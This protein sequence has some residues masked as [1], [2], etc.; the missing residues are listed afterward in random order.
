[1]LNKL[2]DFLSASPAFREAFG[3]ENKGVHALYEMAEG[4]RP[5]YAAALSRKTGRQILYI[6]PSDAAAMRAADDCA[7]WLGGG[8]AMLP[9]QE[10]QFTRGVAS[11]ENSFQ[12][13]SV[14]QKARLGEIRVLC[15]PAD[16][17]MNR[18]MPP[19]KY[20]E[21]A[22][23]LSEGGRMEPAQLIEQ[24]VKMGYERVDMVEG[25]GQCALRGAIVDAFSPAE[26]GAT[27]I[28]FWDDE[29]DSIRA[30][31]PISQRSLDRMEE[32]IFYPAVEWLLP[33]EYAPII[34]ELIRAQSA[35]LPNSPLLSNLPPLPETEEEKEEAEKEEKQEKKLPAFR[36]YDTGI[37][38][39]LQD[40]DQL[41]SGLQHPNL[42]LWAGAVQAE[43]AWLWEYLDDP[44]IL[45]EEPE[46]TRARCQDRFGGFAED[47]KLTLERQEA[48][49][50][51]AALLR[52]WEDAAEAL[53]NRPVKL[54]QDLLRGMG[55][56]KP[57]QITRFAGM[58]APKYV[59]RFKEL[60]GEIATWKREG[61]L[62]LLMAG[63]EARSRRLQTAL[64]ELETPTPTW[65]ENQNAAAAM[66]AIWPRT[67]SHGFVLT[68]CKLAVIADSDIFG[69]GYRKTRT[70]K[71]AGEKIE[72]FTDLKEG[73]YVVHEA[74]G[75]GIFRGTVRLQSEGTYRDYLLIQYQGNDK[76]YVPTDQFDRVQKFIGGQ[77]NPPPLN[78]L[79][80]NEWDRQKKK[81]KAG[82]KKLAFDLVALYAARQ[83]NPGHACCEDT[84]WQRQFED[85]FPY[86]LTPDQDKAV[87]DIKRDME[88]NSNMDRLV[89]GDVGYGKTE[90]ALR[91][92]MKAV[93][94]GKQVALL[95]PTTILAQQHYYTMLKRFR[96][97]PVEIDVLSRFRSPKLQ[98]ETMQKVAE[99]KVDILVGT[100]RLLSKD[101]HF[102]DLGLLIVD[103]E[104]RF[105]VAHKEAIKNYK[106]TVD[107]LTL[108]A[109]PIPRTLHMSMV[110][111]RDMSL[112]QTPPEERYPV[113]TYVL[114]YNDAVI[115]DAIMRELSR[116]GQ[117]YFLYNQV[118]SIDQFAARLR[119][120]VPEARIAVGHGQMKENL[121]EDVMLDFYEG[122]FDVLL[123]STIIENG[124]DVPK[125]NTIIIYDA[126]RF[127]L[128]QLYQLR[129]RVGRSTRV[130]YA[131]FTVRPDKMLSE[132]AQKRLSAIREFTAFGSG[133]R[134]AMR[135]L[136]IRGA[137]NIFGPEQSGNVAAV[138]Y[139]MYCRLIEEAVREARGAQ[140]EEIPFTVETR[141][142][143]K[144]D[145]YL[146]VE[147]VK[148]ES[149]RM[150]VF[151]RI[152]LIKKREDREDVIEELIDRFG[153]VPES[154]MN[155]IEIA[156]LRGICG[157][158]GITRVNH[159]A[160]AMV[161][162][163]SPGA[164]PDPMKLYSALEKTDKRLLLSA[165]REPA[166]LLRD[167]KQTVDS[168]LRLS[169]PI[170]EKVEG[171]L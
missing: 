7:A 138:G 4:Q 158:L 141:V 28:E 37:D 40:A 144:V 10:L 55:D 135:D 152:A 108:S 91:A 168:L 107:V 125:A 109:T 50:E 124:L 93:M 89:C 159:V 157:R 161:F 59:S 97:F 169:V 128:S 87:T 171:L 62:V 14:L 149:Q 101:V 13:L 49:P 103:E 134:I 64:S 94:D 102:K 24:L 140:G 11:R 67:L 119:A 22:V 56:M 43:S 110:G 114:D 133:F 106:K 148:G 145:A 26:N 95:A 80:G 39:L 136:E 1:M 73:D 104:Q 146:P 42:S 30:F 118:R 76:L 99:G 12:R 165:S 19:E 29:V 35:R 156:H 84:P 105:G 51:Q 74:H 21:H 33:K 83:A 123:S 117:V 47:F 81:V 18:M 6:A 126:D 69:A 166:I 57:D 122:K 52:T 75:V 45:I 78:S 155:L 44:I 17:I 32:A 153:D 86:E 79:S 66:A 36:V 139:D 170:L 163:L 3:A 27:R 2:L 41:E 71:T 98:K 53:Q 63:G 154:V 9:A 68:E 116:Q 96:D 150:E 127:G 72:A 131:Y 60:A 77:D 54:M 142:E 46:R 92:A 143:I 38:R 8:A 151:K 147:Y 132:T 16:A 115:R 130:A 129:G 23:R 164:S 31:D 167:P 25:K 58:N 5:F 70:R 111:V 48:V 162:K 137:G 120:L 88:S 20:E 82:L 15:V 34:R 160:G 100:H 112:L 121:L 65:E 85:A 113:Q 90:V 61:F